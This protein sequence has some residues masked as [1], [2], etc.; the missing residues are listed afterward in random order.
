ML[1][2][3]WGIRKNPNVLGA[4]SWK[5]SKHSGTLELI[6]TG[7]SGLHC[8]NSSQHQSFSCWSDPGRVNYTSICNLSYGGLNFKQS[9]YL[10]KKK[11]QKGSIIQ[12]IWSIYAEITH[13]VFSSVFRATKMFYHRGYLCVTPTQPALVTW[14]FSSFNSDFNHM[15]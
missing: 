6:Q 11:T 10:E 13:N 12:K 5:Q 4:W 7:S 3:C 8:H 1:W 15:F 14:I 2:T 9:N